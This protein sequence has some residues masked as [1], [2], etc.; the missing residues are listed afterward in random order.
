M[1]CVGLAEDRM[2]RISSIFSRA[3]AVF[4]GREAHADAC[5]AAGGVGRRDP[6][7]LAG[8]RIALRIVGQRQQQVDVLAEPVTAG[9]RNEQ[10]AVG[11]RRHVAA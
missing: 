1:V 5:V 10:P 4:V 9:R 6:A 2:P 7:D 8:D 11:Q 3:G